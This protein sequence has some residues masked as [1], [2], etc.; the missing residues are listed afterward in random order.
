MNQLKFLIIAIPGLVGSFMAI[1]FVYYLY[2]SLNP[3]A[4]PVED[5]HALVVEAVQ[6]CQRLMDAER[7]AFQAYLKSPDVET[8]KAWKAR[9]V[10]LRQLYVKADCRYKRRV[11]KFA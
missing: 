6:L 10:Q 4:R 2:K 5:A 8:L 11:A 1:D 3:N 7:K 9:T